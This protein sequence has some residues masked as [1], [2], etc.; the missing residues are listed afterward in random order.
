AAKELP[1]G[2]RLVRSAWQHPFLWLAVLALLPHVVGSVVNIAYNGLRIELSPEQRAAF[3][4]ITLC[5]N[6]LV[7]PLCLLLLWHLVAPVVRG[8]RGLTGPGAP[9]GPQLANLRRQV[10][11]LPLGAALVSLVGWLPGALLFPLALDWFD[12]PVGGAVYRHFFISFAIAGLI[13]LT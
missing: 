2:G 9:R 3:A 6:V 1:A 12:G 4:R 10:L 5:Y 7:Y 11:R 8:W 13:A